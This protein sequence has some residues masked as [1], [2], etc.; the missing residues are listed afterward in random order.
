MTA[1][2]TRPCPGCKHSSIVSP[3]CNDHKWI[4]TR[5]F[6]VQRHRERGREIGHKGEVEDNAEW[7][8]TSSVNVLKVPCHLSIARCLSITY[9]YVL[10]YTHH[11]WHICGNKCVCVC[12]C[13][14]VCSEYLCCVLLVCICGRM[15][16]FTSFPPWI[17][18][19][20]STALIN[21]NRITLN[22]YK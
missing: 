6:L 4:F 18:H 7:A 8:R 9:T 11:V 14:C 13:V 22:R 12:V 17:S 19:A 21:S 20:A 10:Q 16:W 2:L 3:S 5:E 15:N 1:P